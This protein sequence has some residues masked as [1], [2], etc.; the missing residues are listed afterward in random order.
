MV[1]MARRELSRIERG[2][3]QLNI[4]ISRVPEGGWEELGENA[5]AEVR[6]L[7]DRLDGAVRAA[8]T[9]APHRL[10]RVEAARAAADNPLPREKW[11]PLIVDGGE[12]G[13]KGS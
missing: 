2:V 1:A 4:L 6:E 12:A 7:R 11:K 5:S 9:S 10:A 8:L 13:K 3:E